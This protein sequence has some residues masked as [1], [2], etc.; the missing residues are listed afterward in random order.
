MFDISKKWQDFEKLKFVFNEI[1]PG[2]LS[3][4]IDDVKLG[5]MVMFEFRRRNMCN[6]TNKQELSLLMLFSYFF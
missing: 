5:A 6:R 2:L 3:L 4:T 1:S